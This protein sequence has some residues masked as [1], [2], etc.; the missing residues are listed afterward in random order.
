MNLKRNYTYY[1]LFKHIYSFLIYKLTKTILSTD[2]ENNKIAVCL[3][4]IPSRIK[5]IIPT[6]NS[7]LLQTMKPEKICLFIPYKSKREGCKYKIPKIIKNNKLIT[8]IRCEDYGP[9]TKILPAIKQKDLVGY[10][11]VVMD[12]DTFYHKN[13]IKTLFFIMF[14]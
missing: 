3:T 13:T 4:T 7:I 10:K 1:D 11:L 2:L 6:I 14:Y 12:D 5:N 9:I 8:I